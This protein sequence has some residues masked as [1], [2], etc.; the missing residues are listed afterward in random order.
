MVFV[1]HTT[2]GGIVLDEC[3][4]KQCL[5]RGCEQDKSLSC[6]L[7]LTSW[8]GEKGLLGGGWVRSSLLLLSENSF[9]LKLCFPWFHSN[10]VCLFGENQNQNFRGPHFKSL[11]NAT[12]FNFTCA[13]K[14]LQLHWLKGVVG[15]SEGTRR[16]RVFCLWVFWFCLKVKGRI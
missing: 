9:C 13:L 14:S 7:K 3:R 15:D 1:F 8:C 4:W 5:N 2:V 16:F 10:K 11:T 12:L 6:P